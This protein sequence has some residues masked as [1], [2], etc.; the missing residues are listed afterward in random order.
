LGIQAPHLARQGV[1]E[2]AVAVIANELARTKRMMKKRSGA[3]ALPCSQIDLHTQSR[4]LV[5]KT[6]L[7]RGVLDTAAQ[8][9]NGE[10]QALRSLSP[11]VHPGRG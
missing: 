1:Q 8:G 10:S 3:L 7:K 9:I 5:I 6:N 4:V 2:L 11:L